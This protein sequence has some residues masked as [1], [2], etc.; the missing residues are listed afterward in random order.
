MKYLLSILFLLFNIGLLSQNIIDLEIDSNFRSVPEFGFN[1]NTIRGP[2]WSDLVFNDSV[3]T[4][5]PEILRY[6]GG[7]PADYWDWNT[8][9][10]L[11]QSVLDTAITDTIYTM[12][13]GWYNLDTLDNRPIIFQQA[14]DQ[15]GA[16]GL[17]IMNMMRSEIETGNLSATSSKTLRS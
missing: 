2:G 9:W 4:M 11:P 13:S 10:F 15:I 12:N 8:G 16:E 17:Y 7:G 5:Y 14:L 6:P 1:G 3:A